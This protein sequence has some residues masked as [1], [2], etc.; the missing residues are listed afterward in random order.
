MPMTDTLSP[1]P[2]WVDA[3]RRTDQGEINNR[4][5][6]N[7]LADGLLDEGLHICQWHPE[8][9]ESIY[10][11]LERPNWAPWL[12]ATP[13]TMIGRTKVFPEG[14][15]VIF[16]QDQLAASLSMNRIRWD[17]NSDNLPS[18]D[19]VAGQASTDYRETYQE[20]GNTLVM[21]SM[22]VSPRMQGRRLPARLIDYVG[23]LAPRLGIEHLMG[24][25]RPNQY[26]KAKQESNYQLP[27]WDYC[28]REKPGTGRPLDP[29]LR[30]LSWKGMTLI[31]EDDRAMQVTV[32]RE[33]FEHYQSTYHS[34]QWV[35]ISPG[36]WECGEVGRWQVSGNQATYQES[37]VWGRMPLKQENHQGARAA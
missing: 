23:L 27:F 34:D 2:D 26:G 3:D 16:H 35:E 22:N 10:H 37:N 15:L 31:Q 1:F 7:M 18:W 20:E 33:E 30:S 25:Y 19:E 13:E 36:C 9:V 11:Q 29:W 24:S 21:M 28:Q 14:Q 8:M 32:S 17:G 5:E 6:W 12:E 4:L